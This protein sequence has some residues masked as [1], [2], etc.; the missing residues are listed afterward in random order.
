ML[1]YDIHIGFTLRKRVYILSNILYPEQALVD[2]STGEVCGYIYSN[3]LYKAAVTERRAKE[4]GLEC[5]DCLG[6]IDLDVVEVVIHHNSYALVS[7][8]IDYVSFYSD[9]DFERLGDLICIRGYVFRSRD[10][11]ACDNETAINRCLSECDIE[12]ERSFDDREL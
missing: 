12:D 11:V 1:L 2:I 8:S 9:S 7:R 4:L 10:F 3:G 6:V 5:C